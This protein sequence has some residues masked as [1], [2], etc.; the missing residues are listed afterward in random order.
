[1]NFSKRFSAK[2][3]KRKEHMARYAGLRSFATAKYYR[4]LFKGKLAL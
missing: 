4:R 3:A 2:L 1:M